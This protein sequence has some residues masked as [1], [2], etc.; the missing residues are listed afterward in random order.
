MWMSS[1]TL[2]NIVYGAVYT[3]AP[4][5]VGGGPGRPDKS[6]G[7]PHG[8]D[9][10]THTKPR[11]YGPRPGPAQQISSRWDV[12]R[13]DPSNFQMMRC[14]PAPPIRF[15]NLSALPSLARLI[16]KALNTARPGLSHFSLFGP[17]P[18]HHIFKITGTA[19]P[20]P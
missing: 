20:S 6:R 14:G 18:A 13:P 2:V 9:R 7:P 10:G 8:L 11:S 15:S 12:A 4:L 1:C 5:F 19:R 17:D 16:F 3:A